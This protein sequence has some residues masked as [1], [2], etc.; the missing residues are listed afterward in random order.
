MVSQGLQVLTPSRPRPWQDLVDENGHP[1]GVKKLRKE[2]HRDGDWHRAVHIWLL[3]LSSN[4]LLLQKRAD[5][6]D[7]WPSLWDISSAGHISAGDTGLGTCQKEL[8]EELGLILPPEAF[9]PLFVY[10]QACVTN[11]GTFINNEFDLVYLVTT[12]DR[13][14]EDAIKVQEEEVAG[15]KVCTLL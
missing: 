14:P 9:A 1:L 6:K 11:G 10:R 15:F 2:V 4:E 12:R 5:D 7:S 8:E 13:V 3:S